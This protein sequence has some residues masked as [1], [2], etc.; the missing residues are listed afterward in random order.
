MLI[1]IPKERLANE[2][3]VAAT[4][5][6]VE[7]LIKLGFSVTVEQGAG[8]RAS[9]DDE[10][11]IAAGATVSTTESVWQS[12]IVLKV[13]APDD[14]EI[15]LT[16]AG[17]TL[18]SFIWPAQNP[19]L[20]EKLAARNVTVMAMDSVPRISRAQA[21][22][23]LS[24]MANIA[25]YRAIVEAA[26]E[27][28]RFFTG[29][30]TAAG[31][32]PPAKVMIIGAGV[33]GLAAIGA[34]GSLGAIV[35]AFDTR[36]EVK[37]QVQS[38][39]A[40]FLEL[41]FEEEAGSGDGYAKV[42]SEAFI[43][44]EMELFAAQAKEVDII[45]TTALIPG[46][47]APKL[48]TAEMVAS[49]KPGSVIVDLAAATGGNC[50]LTVA[51][52]VTLTRNGVKIIGYTDLPSRLPTQSSQLYGTNLVNLLKL[53]CKEK[54]GE[55]TVDF[56]DVVVRGVTVIREGEVTWPAPP[57]QVSAAPKAAQA[58]IEPK[59]KVE[60]KPVSPWRKYLL[61]A[62]AVVLFAC[63]ANVAPP[64]FLSHFTVFALS[65]VVGYYVV[66]N[67]SHALHT[68]LMSV[69]NAISGIIVVGAVL[70]MGHGGWVTFLAFVA[71][72]IA[73]INIF[74]GFTVTQ[75]MLKMFRKN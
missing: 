39:G 55:I 71:V 48:I 68:P 66:W 14:Q 2:S 25:G 53:L 46:K 69:T 72:L 32:V 63:L 24:S 58:A 5:K 23:A 70:Q 20:L 10:S 17:S 34:A 1:G 35:R 11:F 19:A 8:I 62:L 15:E 28:G 57:I 18:V 4:P 56:D 67:V 42:M 54:N 16:R 21:L 41:D 22:D 64:E 36:P 52:Q 6:T 26:H 9:F 43:K 37:E 3:R 47:P 44:A 50:D 30:I 59:A 38:M 74:G 12:D 51:D 29:Q 31:K 60:A 13:N 33:A 75:R 40:E 7:Q 27:F 65:C 73:S 49:M 45:V 61:L